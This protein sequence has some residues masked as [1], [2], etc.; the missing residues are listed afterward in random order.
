MYNLKELMLKSHDVD[1]DVKAL[2]EN[3]EPIK[4]EVCA[5]IS[6]AL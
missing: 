5:S 2:S 4:A 3:L 1:G 6:F